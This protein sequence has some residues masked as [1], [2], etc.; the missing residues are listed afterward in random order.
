MVNGLEGYNGRTG[1]TLWRTAPWRGRAST[2]STPPSRSPMAGGFLIAI[3]AMA[4]AF[5]GAFFGE[6]SR[7][8][9]VGIGAG[10]LAALL[11][12]LRDRR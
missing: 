4:G 2:M 11:L 5:G 6:S 3:G 8:F 7:G 9:F 1:Q 12:W 10:A